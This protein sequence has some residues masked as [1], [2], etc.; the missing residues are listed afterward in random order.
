MKQLFSNK[1]FA[2][3]LL[4]VIILLLF[5]GFDTWIRRSE[6]ASPGTNVQYYKIVPLPIPASL[7]FAGEQV[8]LDIFYVT[9][10]LDRELTVNTYWHS[11]TLQLIRKST[12]WFPVFDSI[13]DSH[14][15]PRD[16]KYLCVIESGMSNV[17]SPAN[18]VGFWQFIKSTAE[19]YGL[20]V[21]REIDERYHVLKSTEA[22]CRY[23]LDSY[24]IYKDWTLVA[25]SYNAGRNG[26][27]S[28]MEEQKAGSYYDMLLP[29]ETSRYVYRILAVKLIFENPEAYGFYLEETDYYRP[30][31]TRTVEVSGKV[32]SWGDFA[33]SHGVSYMVLKYFNPWLRQTDLK[34]RR[35]KTYTITL[36]EPP[37]DLT[38]EKVMSAEKA[39]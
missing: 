23:L 16:F 39:D 29:E 6:K 25:A 35:K 17:I 36:P 22:A 21:S 1:I 14:G 30:I 20:E 5:V 15:V 12:R 13:L 28:R 19:E 10:A 27:T 33:K 26:I 11:S 8:P 4:L 2:R 32:P 24:E 31:P 38:Y 37:Y 9:E 7:S 34:N 3:I 18:A